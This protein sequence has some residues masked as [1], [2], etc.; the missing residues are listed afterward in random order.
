MFEVGKK[1]KRVKIDPRISCDGDCA[2][3][4]VVTIDEV[5]PDQ[6][7]SGDITADCFHAVETGRYYLQSDFEL[8][9]DTPSPRMVTTC[10]IGARVVRGRDRMPG[11]LFGIG[12]FGTIEAEC[13]TGVCVV[14]WEDGKRGNYRI[15]FEGKFDLYYADEQ[16]KKE[17][18]QE[19][20]EQLGKLYQESID[21]KVEKITVDVFKKAVNTLKDLVVTNKSDDEGNDR[22]SSDPAPV[23][24]QKKKA[25]QPPQAMIMIG[26]RPTLMYGSLMQIQGP[27]ESETQCAKRAKKAEGSKE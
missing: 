27:T 12:M 9:D 1:V 11:Y 5:L 3:N 21:E 16:P 15:G 8:I 24:T 26:S 13:I 18:T 20:A 6:Q 4:G 2:I 22:N 25:D 7:Y 23:T 17:P 19:Y 14:L 10:D